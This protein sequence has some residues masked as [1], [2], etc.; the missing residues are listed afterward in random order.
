MRD[1]WA[2]VFGDP[3]DPKVQ[4]GMKALYKAATGGKA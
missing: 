3:K 4:A 2:A 1:Q